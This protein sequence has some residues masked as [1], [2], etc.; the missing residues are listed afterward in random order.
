[1]EIPWGLAEIA[2]YSEEIPQR[3][4]VVIRMRKRHCRPWL[5]ALFL[6]FSFEAFAD[7][8]SDQAA[9]LAGSQG[10]EWVFKRWETLMG[11]GNRCLTGESYRFKTDHSVVITRCVAGQVERKTQA[12]GIESADALETHVKVGTTSYILKFWDERGKHCMM[13]RI[14][15]QSKIE[16]TMDKI[17]Q[18][19]AD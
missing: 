12:W 4:K 14:I 17:F 11:Q 7:Q 8:A 18:L 13:L 2:P 9:M 3:R 16:P 15:G 1:M 5:V 19:E 6:L 10:R